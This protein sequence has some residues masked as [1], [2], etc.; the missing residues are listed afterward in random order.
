[1][2]ASSIERLNDWFDTVGAQGAAAT[3]PAARAERGRSNR[4]AAGALVSLRG[5]LESAWTSRTAVAPSVVLA[6]LTAVVLA[7]LI[8]VAVGSD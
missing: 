7:A 6:G 1:M 5:T 4:T 2:S 8:A 3:D